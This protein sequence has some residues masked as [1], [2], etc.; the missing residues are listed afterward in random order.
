MLIF[1]KNNPTDI[2]KIRKVLVLEGIFSETTY[3]CVSSLI[4]TSFRQGA[5]ILPFPPP[6]NQPLRSLPRLGIIAFS[7]GS[8][9]TLEYKPITLAEL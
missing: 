7:S 4:L 8:Y 1:C 6:Q 9:G 5:V 2:S 3:L